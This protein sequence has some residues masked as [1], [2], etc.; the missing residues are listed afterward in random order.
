MRTERDQEG[1][2]R[3]ESRSLGMTSN[4]QQGTRG[5]KRSATKDLEYDFNMSGE[6]QRLNEV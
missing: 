5:K 3:L 1:F 2:P 6:R 4:D